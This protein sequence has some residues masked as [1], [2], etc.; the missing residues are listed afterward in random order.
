MT[1]RLQRFQIDAKESKATLFLP[2]LLR[3]IT[4]ATGIYGPTKDQLPAR[5]R[6]LAPGAAL[7]FEAEL[8]DHVIVSDMLRSPESSLRARREKRGAQ[9]PGY[10]GHNYGYSI[11]IAVAQTMKQLDLPAKR[12]LDEWMAKRGWHCHRRDHRCVSEEWHYNYF[13]TDVGRFVRASDK[14]TSAGLER[15]IVKNYGRWWT[16]MSPQD[17]QRALQRLGLYDGDL[18][19]KFG[20][21]SREAARVF[22]RAWG[23]PAT[24]KL[25]LTMRRTLAFVSA[26]RILV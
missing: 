8:A 12:D 20:P 13:G 3:E 7:S 21:L 23:L 1:H 16:K 5:M 17:A 4:R 2:L 6:Y 25:D 14:R 9:R 26:D 15:K 19:G 18:D 24:G 10:S 11:D 22:Q